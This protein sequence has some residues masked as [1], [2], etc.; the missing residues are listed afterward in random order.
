[1]GDCL[2]PKYFSSQPKL[3]YVLHLVRHTQLS[4]I[5]RTM[6]SGNHTSSNV[7]FKS[8]KIYLLCEVVELPYEGNISRKTFSHLTVSY[9][10]NYN[11]FPVDLN[12][13]YCYLYKM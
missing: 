13:S 8:H 2:Q 4:I 9:S 7:D 12:F 10:E 1:M 5:V 3:G 11:L 6:K